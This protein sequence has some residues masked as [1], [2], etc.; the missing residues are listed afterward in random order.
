MRSS[1]WSSDVCSS[2]LTRFPDDQASVHLLEWPEIGDWTD[3]AL[4]EKWSSLRDLRKIATLAIEPFRRDKTLG[5]SLEAEVS[6]ALPAV[7]GDVLGGVDF[8]E[9]FITAPA[10]IEQSADDGEHGAIRRKDRPKCG[11]CRRHLPQGGQDCE[12]C[13]RC[14]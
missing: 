9:L 11:R 13:H 3:E 7:S 5:S 10:R 1:D 12:S 14:P 2:D 4:G 6:I 8:A